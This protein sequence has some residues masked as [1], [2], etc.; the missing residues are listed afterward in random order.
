MQGVTE[1]RWIQP[2]PLLCWHGVLRQ[3]IFGTLSDADTVFLDLAA[4]S[5]GLAE[6]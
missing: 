1:T 5:M 4:M 3:D 6:M 2:G